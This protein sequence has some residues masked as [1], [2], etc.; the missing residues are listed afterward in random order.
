MKTSS[1][2]TVGLLLAAAALA[3]AA[4]IHGAGKFEWS[5]FYVWVLSPYIVLALIFVLP[6]SQSHARSVA[7]CSA[8]A[9]VLAFTGLLYIDAMWISVSSTSALIFIFA[10][11]YLFVGGLIVWGLVWFV[12]KRRAPK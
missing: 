4:M 11:A 9:M 7:G 10:P 2:A 5:P 3:V 12:L 8:A 1:K 6:V